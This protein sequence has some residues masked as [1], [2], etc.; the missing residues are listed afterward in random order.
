MVSLIQYKILHNAYVFIGDFAGY[1][2]HC[3]VM[4]TAE[5]LHDNE[6]LPYGRMAAQNIVGVGLPVTLGNIESAINHWVKEVRLWNNQTA[7]CT[8][9][10]Y[11]CGH[12]Q[13]VSIHCR[14]LQII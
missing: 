8:K 12:Y 9:D 3:G 10:W 7:L 4:G 5:N 11:P 13:N 14:L 1:I 6:W 2:D